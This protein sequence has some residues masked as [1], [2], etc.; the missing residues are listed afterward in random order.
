MRSCHVPPPVPSRTASA[1]SWG[2][3]LAKPTIR[4]VGCF[5]GPNHQTCREHRSLCTSSTTRRVSRQ[6]LTMSA[7]RSTPPR[8]RARACPRCQPPRLVTRLLW[9]VSQDPTLALHRSR[10]ISTLEKKHTKDFVGNAL[11]MTCSEELTPA[12]NSD[13][14]TNPRTLKLRRSDSQAP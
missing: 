5:W 7:T 2:P 1:E 3:N 13:A 12:M 9:S 10:S 11:V 14:P 8:P 6:S 4:S